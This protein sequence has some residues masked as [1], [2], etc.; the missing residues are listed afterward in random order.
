MT[1]VLWLRHDFTLITHKFKLWR[2]KSADLF[3]LP[4]FLITMYFSQYHLSC[5][6]FNVQSLAVKMSTGEVK[7]VDRSMGGTRCIILCPT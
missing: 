5:Y 7:A 3:E 6:N 1:A 4:L 2:G